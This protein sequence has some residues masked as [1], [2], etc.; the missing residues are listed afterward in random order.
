[1]SLYLSTI[2]VFLIVI[3]LLV[4]ILLVAKSYLV[5][6]GKV[7]V[8]I[9]GEKEIQERAF[10]QLFQRTEYSFLQLV[11]VRDLAVSANVRYLKAVVKYWIQRRDILPVNR[12]K[13]T[14]V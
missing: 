11:V 1:M 13:T 14:G 4:V 5:S 9:N 12:L 10:C 6:S 3:L 8:T 2:A 7:K